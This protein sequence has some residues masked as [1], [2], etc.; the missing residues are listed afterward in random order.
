M[1]QIRNSNDQGTSAEDARWQAV[2]ARDHDCDGKFF[3]AVT[4]TGVYCRPSCAARHPHRKNVKFYTHAR[5]A[6]AAGFRSCKRCKPNG[7]SLQT[8]YAKTIAEVCRLIEKSSEPL[9]LDDLASGAGL[10]PYH[11]HRIFK[12]ITGVTPKSYA[13]AVRQKRVRDGLTRETTVTHAIYDAGFASTGR[14]YDS[15]EKMLGM[16]PKAFRSGGQSAVIRFAVG[17]CS[18]GAILVAESEKGICAVLLGDD[19]AALL[20]DLQDRFPKAELVGGDKAYEKRAA[21]VIACTENPR[22]KLDLPLDIRGTAF[23][24]RV[25]KALQEIPCGST[26][27]YT[28]IAE[29]LGQP[30]SVRAVAGACGANALA[31]IVPCHRVV[32][33]DGALSGYR[34]GIE[35]KRELLKREGKF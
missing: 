4:T 22:L 13:D 12:S 7:K 34:W 27:S 26:A 18:L 21:N 8:R 6:E 17:D 14:F 31:V 29:R 1:R 19:P 10:S 20:R 32:R 28:D 11:F 16:T 24:H 23:Q 9:S 15:S 35:R 3:Y 33:N 2:L 30:K 25:W 5:D